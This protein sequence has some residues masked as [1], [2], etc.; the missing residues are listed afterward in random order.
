MLFRSQRFQ[1]WITRRLGLSPH[2]SPD[3]LARAIQERLK[4]GDKD[5]A[6]TLSEAASARYRPDLPQ[7]EALAI[8]KSLYSHA[9]KLKLFQFTKERT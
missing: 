9:V 6:Q 4:S 3:D 8:V 5:F 7:K 1:Y 2:A